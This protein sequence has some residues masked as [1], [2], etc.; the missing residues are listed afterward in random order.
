M[1]GSFDP[2]EVISHRLRTTLKETHLT[3]PQLKN[4]C[5]GKSCCLC[6]PQTSLP[7]SLL[8]QHR[9]PSPLCPLSPSTQH[10]LLGSC[11][12]PAPCSARLHPVSS[13]EFSSVF[14][15]YLLSSFLPSVF[16][17]EVLEYQEDLTMKGE[18]CLCACVI[19]YGGIP[20]K[21]NLKS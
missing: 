9:T 6:F 21:G 15:L 7:V 3:L 4:H 11:R 17:Q 18:L 19:T 20:L 1:K 2:K 12:G 16:L 8:G 14:S 10:L 5:P 13:S